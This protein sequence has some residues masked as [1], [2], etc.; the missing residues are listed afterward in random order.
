MRTES[1]HG[2]SPIVA[3][4]SEP[5]R[6]KAPA[7]GGFTR[8]DSLEGLT[9]EARR[10]VHEN[11]LRIRYGDSERYE[12]YVEEYLRGARLCRS[13]AELGAYGAH[14]VPEQ[15]GERGSTALEETEL[16]DGPFRP[17]SRVWFAASKEVGDLRLRLEGK[18][19]PLDV[20][21]DVSATA[22]VQY[23]VRAFGGTWSA[24]GGAEPVVGAGAGGVAVV[25]KGNGQSEVGFDAVVAGAKVTLSGH[26][27]EGVEVKARVLP[28]VS[29][30][31]RKTAA[32]VQHSL[33][34]GGR[35]GG[36][37]G[38][39]NVQL[40]ARASIGVNLLTPELVRE[41][42]FGKSFWEKKETKD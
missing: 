16:F 29:I 23:G 39:P 25:V 37:N 7:W 21:F 9:G 40:E 35:L 36:A 26:G 13:A 19:V 20:T 8:L 5:P 10:R 12:A 30:Y 14:A 11:N 15:G 41:A 3:G 2:P 33:A 42:L 22:K 28:G 1:S 18:T 31:A 17:M 34:V 32:G 24:H 27:V 38:S 6:P 4:D